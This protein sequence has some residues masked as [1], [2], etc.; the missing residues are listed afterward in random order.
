MPRGPL[1]HGGSLHMPVYSKTPSD[2]SLDSL[3]FS[4][5]KPSARYRRQGID[6]HCVQGL[7]KAPAHSHHDSAANSAWAPMRQHLAPVQCR[8]PVHDRNLRR[9]GAAQTLRPSAFKWRQAGQRSVAPGSLRLRHSSDP[10]IQ[11]CQAGA[12]ANFSPEAPPRFT[13]S[14]GAWHSLHSAKKPRQTIWD[15][16]VPWS[17][18]LGLVQWAAV[19][20]AARDEGG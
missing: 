18:S 8:A 3:L 15:R 13:R 10:T 2:H 20:A 11:L 14:L 5:C 19:A 12:L 17:P 7:R 6:R 1:V 4:Q 9:S 16:A